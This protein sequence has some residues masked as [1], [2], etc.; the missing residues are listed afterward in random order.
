MEWEVLGQIHAEPLHVCQADAARDARTAI[1][2]V[3]AALEQIDVMYTT[4]L[5][6]YWTL[7]Q[8]NIGFGNGH[9]P[10]SQWSWAGSSGQ[11]GA[12]YRR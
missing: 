3:K 9:D 5:P 8:P 4:N 12:A 1:D 7:V 6:L 11:G 10:R 2:P